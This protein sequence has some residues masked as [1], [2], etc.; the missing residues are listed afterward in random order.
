MGGSGVVLRRVGM[1]VCGVELHS[2]ASGVCRIAV[3]VVVFAQC[4]VA[5][6]DAICYV[7]SEYQLNW[8]MLYNY[9]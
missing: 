5:C 1:V 7:V 2:V 6:D 8:D 3:R 4:I 9:M